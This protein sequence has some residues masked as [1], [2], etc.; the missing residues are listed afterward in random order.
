MAAKMVRLKKNTRMHVCLHT[1]NTYI[2]IYICVCVHI[3]IYTYYILY[4]A[5]PKP[6]LPAL[7]ITDGTG[8]KTVLSPASGS[9]ES[10][11]L[12]GVLEDGVCLG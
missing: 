8:P 7:G 1:F 9:P 2:Y 6:L 5:N 10:H 11:I 12:C 3:Y 4:R